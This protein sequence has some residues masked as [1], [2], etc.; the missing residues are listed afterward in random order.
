MPSPR[1][2]R[3]TDAVEFLAQIICV[4][5]DDLN[6]FLDRSLDNHMELVAEFDVI[7]LGRETAKLI[8]EFDVILLGRETAKLIAEFDVILLGR[9]TAKLIAEFDVILLGRE[10]AKLIAEFDVILLGRERQLRH[11]LLQLR[12]QIHQILLGR[13]FREGIVELLSYRLLHHAHPPQ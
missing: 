11:V 4:L 1:P 7:L 6:Q 3:N 13:K 8:A 2:Y 10:T 12:A 9:E 5:I